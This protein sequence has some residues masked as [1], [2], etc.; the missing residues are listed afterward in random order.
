MEIILMINVECDYSYSY[1]D[2]CMIKV[3][4]KSNG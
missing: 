4:C 1:Y 2:W 3:F